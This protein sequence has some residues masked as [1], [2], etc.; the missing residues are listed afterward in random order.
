MTEDGDLVGGGEI[1]ADISRVTTGYIH[2]IIYN[3]ELVSQDNPYGIVRE[4]WSPERRQP[5]RR[6]LS[7]TRRTRMPR[8]PR[9]GDQ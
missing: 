8:M 9:R 1:Q 5:T 3:P 4:W 2:H 7:P 6:T